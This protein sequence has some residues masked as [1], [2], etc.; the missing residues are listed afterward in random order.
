MTTTT[1]R[2]KH[3]NLN[4][5]KVH[6]DPLKQFQ[7]WFA[8]AINA[9][10]PLAEAMILATATPDGKPSSRAVLLKHV[11][12]N[13]FVFYTNYRSRKGKELARNPRAALTFSWIPL[14]RQIRIEGIVTK[15]SPEDSDRYFQS[16]PRDSQIS[17]IISAQSEEIPHRNV[18]ERMAKKLSERYK[19]KPIPR[20][21]QWGGYCLKPTRV[22]FWQ[23]RKA[24]L[25]DRILYTLLRNGKW[26]IQRLAP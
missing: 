18:L 13:G 20:P 17:A 22:E 1:R 16:R 23:G 8:S 21:L 14:E 4:E 3:Q 25:H 11:D 26:K 10:L 9:K 5:R 7:R 2:H 24:R 12:H 6:P 19:N 15:V